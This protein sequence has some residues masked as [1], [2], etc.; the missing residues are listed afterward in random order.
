MSNETELREEFERAGA[1]LKLDIPNVP[2]EMLNFAL[3][4]G[5]FI[6]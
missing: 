1:Q 5:G 4:A 3:L 2:A 6:G